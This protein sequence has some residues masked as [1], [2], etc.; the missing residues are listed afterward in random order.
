M[1]QQKYSTQTEGKI[2]WPS[3]FTLVLDVTTTLTMMTVLVHHILLL[4]TVL[5]FSLLSLILIVCLFLIKGTVCHKS[6]PCS[7]K[8]LTQSFKIM[9]R[10]CWKQLQFKLKLHFQL[11]LMSCSTS[12]G[13]KKP[14]PPLG[15][16]PER[17]VLWWVFADRFFSQG[18]RLG[19][20]TFTWIRNQLHG[21]VVWWSHHPLWKALEQLQY[22]LWGRQ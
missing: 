20:T 21:T 4:S 2:K 16:G 18:P 8:I 15:A 3:T 17:G 5:W 19:P 7:L 12:A 1:M 10:T 13:M 11:K 9:Q 6:K 14:G 22:K